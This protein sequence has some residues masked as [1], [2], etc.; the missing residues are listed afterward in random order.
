MA[1]DVTTH[2]AAESSL[3]T[4]FDQRLTAMVLLPYAAAGLI[5]PTLC[6]AA[7]PTP[8]LYIHPSPFP[9]SFASAG[10]D[11]IV[12]TAPQTNAVLA[13]HLGVDKH[14]N[15]PIASTKQ[16]GGRDWEL[17]L[18]DSTA[19]SLATALPTRQRVVVVLECGKQGCDDAIPLHLRPEA[20][21]GSRPIVLPALAPNSYLAALSLHLHRL[22]DSL[23]LDPTSV[24]GL[25]DFVEQGIKAVKGWQGWVSEE[26]GN[27]IGWHDGDN[28]KATVIDEPK[29]DNAGLVN[30]LDLLD[31]VCPLPVSPLSARNPGPD[32]LFATP[33]R[34]SSS[35]LTSTSLPISPTRSSATRV[36]TRRRTTSTRARKD[37]QTSLP[38]R[39]FT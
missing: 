11:P 1:E 25:Q 37:R 22:A 27:W 36:S 14:V 4:L 6:Y 3:S 15:W 18:G 20:N 19:A 35:S 29:I 28:A 12:L 26:L 5:L 8:Q 23:G 34:R 2:G 10:D 9:P 30:D 24:I 32:P 39:S 17:A 16:V 38:L 21:S 33:S 7:A 31:G 13:H